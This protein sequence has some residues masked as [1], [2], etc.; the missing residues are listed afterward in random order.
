MAVSYAESNPSRQN[1]D[2]SVD[3]LKVSQIKKVLDAGNVDYRDCLERRELVDRLKETQDFIPLSAQRLLQWYL[4]G[5]DDDAISPISTA[6]DLNTT[7]SPVEGQKIHV[8]FIR[9]IIAVE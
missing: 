6:V 1:N 4:Q 2:V 7:V 9:A 8:Q 5:F 3:N